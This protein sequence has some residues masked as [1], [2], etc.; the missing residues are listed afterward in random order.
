V[1]NRPIKL[2]ALDIDGVLTDGRA[3]LSASGEEIK[4][5]SFHD[6]DAL[7]H[8]MHQ[9]MPVA[10]VT[11]ESGSMTEAIA[12]RFG[13]PTVITGAKDKLA[14]L[15]TLAAGRDLLLADIC[16]VGDSDRDAPALRAVGLGL[17][18]CNATPAARAA[19]HRV[20][21]RAGG[22]GALAEAADLLQRLA[23][24]PDHE[25]ELRRIVTD[26]LA[27]HQ[28]L[29][30]ESLPVLAEIARVLI[31][32]L[33]TG[34]KLLFFGSGG[35]AAEFAGCFLKESAPFAAVALT[36][37]TSL[38]AAGGD[39]WDFAEIFERQVRALA[40]PGD[41]V[42]GIT[43]SG[44]SPNVLRGVQAGRTIGAVAVGFTGAGG[45]PLRDSTDVCFCAPSDA[46]PRVQELHVLAWHAICEI[47]EHALFEERK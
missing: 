40:H 23:N 30:N 5:V 44:R 35:S 12:R 6:L 4:P 42:I 24:P 34:H 29:S 7:T 28:R 8:L 46:T 39:D 19:A 33:Q 13:V 14:V 18:P 36:T 10:L 43:T 32:A 41:V 17:A 3:W 27:A 25:T 9:G 11:G 21:R 20:L 37:D 45:G 16:Y 2:L 15:Q 1:V 38:L 26:S 47:V 31:D 22:D